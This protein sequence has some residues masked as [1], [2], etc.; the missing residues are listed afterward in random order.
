MKEKLTSQFRNE[1]AWCKE[2][3]IQCGGLGQNS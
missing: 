3:K 1:T 2:K